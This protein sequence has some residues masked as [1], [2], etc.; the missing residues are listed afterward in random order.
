M[1]LNNIVN[2]LVKQQLTE[3]RKQPTFGKSNDIKSP[4]IAPKEKLDLK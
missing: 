3:I 4:D 1:N 2:H